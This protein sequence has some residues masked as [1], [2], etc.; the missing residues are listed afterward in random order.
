MVLYSSAQSCRAPAASGVAAP[1]QGHATRGMLLLQ[2]RV[3]RD[4]LD[5]LPDF[6]DNFSWYTDGI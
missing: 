6:L 2:V 1:P 5:Q 3:Y 4:H